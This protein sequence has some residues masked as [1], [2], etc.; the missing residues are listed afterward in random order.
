MLQ[1]PASDPTPLDESDGGGGRLLGKEGTS[2][3]LSQLV[4]S[5]GKGNAEE[6]QDQCSF[7]HIRFSATQ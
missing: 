6:R 4:S 7:Q 1:T 5:D 2:I 3:D